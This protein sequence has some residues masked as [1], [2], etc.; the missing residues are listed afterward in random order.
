MNLDN[1]NLIKVKLEGKAKLKGL[2]SLYLHDL[3]EFAEDL[4]INE[5]GLFE[6]EGIDLY[7]EN[8]E[9]MPFF[10]CSQNEVVGFILVNSGKFVGPNIDY[11]IHELFILKGFRRKGIAHIT[12]K[13][14]LNSYMGKYKVEQLKENKTAIGFWRNFYEVQGIKYIEEKEAIDGFECLIQI[15]NN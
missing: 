8:E 12:I 9:L 13:K 10:I 3:S 4:K 2:M 5:D 15:F 7:F 14:I 6:Y 1:I 11:S